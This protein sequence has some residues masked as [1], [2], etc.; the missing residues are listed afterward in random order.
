MKP[1]LFFILLLTLT[2]VSVFGQATQKAGEG[3]W[4]NYDFVPGNQVLA[5]HD[6]Q[7]VYVGNFPDRIQYLA[8]D[9]EVVQLADGNNV[10]RTNNEGRFVVSTGASLPE[11]FTVEFRVQ[12]TDKRSKVMMYSP[13]EKAPIKS[14][15]STLAALLDH[16]GTGLSVGK[17]EEGPKSLQKLAIE[18]YM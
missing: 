2:T 9:M 16:Q 13:T 14:P 15:G 5:Y 4:A 7:N 11:K 10:L 6:F 3:V 1:F 12:A 18:T 17:Y 8:G